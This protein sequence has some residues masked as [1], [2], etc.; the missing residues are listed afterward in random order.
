[1]PCIFLLVSSYKKAEADCTIALKLDS[2]YVKAY[3]RRA[4][5]RENQNFLTE[6]HDDLLKVLELEPNNK[7]S[8]AAI[9]LLEKRLGNIKKVCSILIVEFH[10]KSMR[11]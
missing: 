2:T 9:D 4:I 6:A 3:H 5:A 8:Q 11:V 7:E 1:M 10:D